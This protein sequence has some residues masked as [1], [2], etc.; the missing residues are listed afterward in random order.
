MDPPFNWNRGA[1]YFAWGLLAVP[2]KTVEK[3]IMNVD[4]GLS[5]I[6]AV[7]AEQIAIA[8]ALF[9]TAVLDE[10]TQETHS[11]YYRQRH[12]HGPDRAKRLATWPWGYQD[13]F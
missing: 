1:K 12:L 2:Q 13:S 6:I 5:G 10:T 7:S 11:T 9:R 3:I 4:N 8:L